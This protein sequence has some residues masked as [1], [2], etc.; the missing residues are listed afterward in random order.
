M[1]VLLTIKPAGNGGLRGSSASSRVFHFCVAVY[2]PPCWLLDIEC[3]DFMPT[4][5]Q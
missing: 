3:V 2:L 5:W 4:S 1:F